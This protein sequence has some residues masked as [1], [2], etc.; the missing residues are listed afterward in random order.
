MLSAFA[1]PAEAATVSYSNVLED[2]EKDVN[3]NPEDY[4]AD[5]TDYSLKII[6]VVESESGELFLY[7]YQP[8][9]DTKDL[10]AAKV[11]MSLQE[12]SDKAATYSLYNLTWLNSD[13]VFDKY[14]VNDFVVSD[15]AYR[16]YT[17]STIY[18]KHDE[19]IDDPALDADDTI[20]YVGLAVGQSWCCYSYNGEYNC[21]SKKIDFVEVEIQSVGFT[22]F[23]EGFKLYLDKCDSHF[24]AFSI[25][26]FDVDHIY[27]ADVSYTYKTATRATGLGL[28]GETNYS[29]PVT[30]NLTISDYQQGSNDGDGLFGKKYTWDRISTVEQFISETED[31]TNEFLSN[32]DREN[33][34]KSEFVFR[35]LETSRSTSSSIS[36]TTVSYWTSVTEVAILRLHFLSE[37][38]VYNLGVVSDIVSDDGIP[39]YIVTIGDNFMNQEWWQ[40]L[41]ALLGAIILGL[42]LSLLLPVFKAI[43]SVVWIVIKIIFKFCYNIILFPYKIFVSLFR[44]K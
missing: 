18:R 4:P 25:E 8:S 40:I 44:K 42:L 32:S 17:I 41:V 14:I 5:P 1:V 15:E 29:E 37:G 22:Q 13:G 36:G 6:Q 38:K 27:D 9:N 23:P 30:E 2:L 34:S 12:P 7:V 28:T 19:S 20:D 31:Y 3:F 39:D 21:E 35:F 11:N 33:L 26:G 24:V 43:F 10:K 16:Y